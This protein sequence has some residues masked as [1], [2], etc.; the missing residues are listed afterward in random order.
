MCTKIWIFGHKILILSTQNTNLCQLSAN[1]RAQ[2]IYSVLNVMGGSDVQKKKKR[3]MQRHHCFYPLLKFWICTLKKGKYSNFLFFP[4]SVS[5][6]TAWWLTV[7]P[8]GNDFLLDWVLVLRLPCGMQHS[9]CVWL[10]VE[11]CQNNSVTK[12][13]IFLSLFICNYSLFFTSVPV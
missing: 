13:K 8:S 10:C 7:E 4:L 1:L 5:N 12:G 6:N 3:C 9:F 11:P 2:F